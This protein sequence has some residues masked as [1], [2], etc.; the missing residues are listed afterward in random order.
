MRSAYRWVPVCLETRGD[1]GGGVTITKPQSQDTNTIWALVPPK[2]AL[3]HRSRA[4][5]WDL[6]SPKTPPG[7]PG[8]PFWSQEQSWV[9]LFLG[10]TTELSDY[11]SPSLLRATE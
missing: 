4:E 1:W 7:N 9:T 3:A 5:Y 8:E 11:P 6:R 2:P 10:G